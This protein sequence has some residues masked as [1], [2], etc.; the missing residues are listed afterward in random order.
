MRPISALFLLF[1]TVLAPASACAAD[2]VALLERWETL[3]DTDAPAPRFEEGIEFL[4]NYPGWPDE[5]AIKLRTE[6][7]AF[8]D[9]PERSVMREFCEVLPP[10]SGRGMLAC[11]IAQAAD[12]KSCSKW[13]RQGWIQGDFAE[14]EEQAILTRYGDVLDADAHLNRTER[15]LYEGKPTAAKRM[16]ELLPVAQRPYYQ[17]WIGLSAR[18]AKTDDLWRDLPEAQQKSP[19]ILFARMHNSQ[20]TKQLDALIALAKRAPADAPYPEH[21][22]DLRQIAAREAITQQHFDDA[23]AIVRR[24]GTLDGED[25][26]EALWLKGWLELEFTK[27]SD[28]AYKDFETLYESVKTPVSKARAAYWAGRAAKKNGNADVAHEWYVKG[29]AYPTVFYG[30]LSH[31]A[32]HPDKPL[33]LPSAPSFSADHKQAFEDNLL[34]RIAR[35][36]GGRDEPKLRD[37]FLIQLASSAETQNQLTLVTNL[38]REVGGISSAVKVAKYAL[39]KH[40]VMP[41]SGWPTIALP[42]DI[43]IEPAL[44]LAITRQESEFDP[45]AISPA[46][47]RGLMQLLPSTAQHVAEQHELPY[48]RG[49]LYNPEENLRLGTT[50]LGQMIDGF[51]G[52][53]ILGIASYNAGPGTVRK[54]R[55]AFG[56]PPKTLEGSIDW[57]ESIPFTETRNYVQRV[58]ENTQVYR[59]LETPD[60]PPELDKDLVR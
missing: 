43:A 5:K 48:G 28:D 53:Y 34:V 25:L 51:D 30:Q 21:W 55:N 32:L 15:L 46:D 47:A 49:S 18:D 38:A 24:H 7:A 36:L 17:A 57:I 39:R 54:W 56:A 14:N 8:T 33:V 31:L 27:N 41:E 16:I 2:P 9:R 26:A 22:W 11:A 59:T 12:E 23:L 44:A 40:A 1:T 13:L 20:K 4:M 37:R 10:I 45:E 60:A 52:S 58:L 35:H 3:R 50:Y 29:A 6:A 42:K 19:G